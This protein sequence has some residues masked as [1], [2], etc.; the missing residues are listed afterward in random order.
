MAR[1]RYRWTMTTILVLFLGA[2]V[3]N[4]F[5]YSARVPQEV[6]RFVPRPSAARSVRSVRRTSGHVQDQN[7]S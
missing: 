7:T 4:I 6:H 2:S 1:I 3:L 5:L